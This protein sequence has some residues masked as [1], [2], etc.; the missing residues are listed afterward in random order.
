[1]A[2]NTVAIL[3]FIPAD[4]RVEY[5]VRTMRNVDEQSSTQWHH[6]IYCENESLVKRVHSLL[7]LRSS[8]YPS[9]VTVQ[10][11][12]QIERDTLSTYEYIC[13]HPV[14]DTWS[15]A[16]LEKMILELS[17]CPVFIA[18]VWCQYQRA[19]EA[20]RGKVISFDSVTPG[21][22][23]SGALVFPTYP[24]I[25][26]SQFIQGLYYTSSIH[27]L[28]SINV[29]VNPMTFAAQI[30]IDQDILAIPDTLATYSIRKE[31]PESKL[32]AQQTRNALFRMFP[33][34]HVTDE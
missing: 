15:P 34:L 16:F 32:E 28:A 3:T 9:K 1:M 23:Y 14:Q 25:K 4:S 20:I 6:F 22:E 10:Q 31:T 8:A 5:I 13:I 2:N 18:G 7:S 33:R 12:S 24:Y 29:T 26:D 11:Y 27:F 17:S 30:L 21:P 19:Q